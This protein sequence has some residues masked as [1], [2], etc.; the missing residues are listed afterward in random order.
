[1]S[2]F[3]FNFIKIF[4]TSHIYSFS[5]SYPKHSNLL[6]ISIGYLKITLHLVWHRRIQF[7]FSRPKY[8]KNTYIYT[9]YNTYHKI[10]QV[11]RDWGINS[12]MYEMENTDWCYSEQLIDFHM[13][14]ENPIGI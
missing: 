5:W 11:Y 4:W 2:K 7:L 6:R 14:R 1:M 8:C 12:F 13:Q 10:K 3:Y 9:G